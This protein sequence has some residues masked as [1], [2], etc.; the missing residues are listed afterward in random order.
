M[1][2]QLVF[3]GFPNRRYIGNQLPTNL[4]AQVIIVADDTLTSAMQD[5]LKANY[6]YQEYPMRWWYPEE[7]TYRRFAYAP[8]IKDVNR[9]DYQDSRKP[10]FTLI[11]VARS[12]GSSI[13]SMHRPSEQ[14]KI[15]RMVAYREVPSGFGSVNFRVYVRNDLVQN[16]NQIRY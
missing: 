8:D 12:V 14:A 4:D 5:Q 3:E 7:N 10:P 11:D 2:V 6:T 15:F 13:W 16:F 1:A 9:Q